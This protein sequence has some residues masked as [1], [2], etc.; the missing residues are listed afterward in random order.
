[1]YKIYTHTKTTKKYRYF[2][3]L[4]SATNYYFQMIIK[5]QFKAFKTFIF[6]RKDKT[7]LK[8]IELN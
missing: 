6:L 8:G 2:N 3:D 4:A 5:Y 7:I 1:M